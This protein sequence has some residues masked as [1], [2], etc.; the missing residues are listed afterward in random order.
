MAG[1]Y[2]VASQ[3]RT[4]QVV[5]PTQVVDVMEIGAFS[6]PSNVYF[7]RYIPF[8]SWQLLSG[9]QGLGF[10][11][12]PIVDAIEDS[13]ASGAAAAVTFLQDIDVASGLLADFLE[14][15]VSYTPA[16]GLLPMTT[17]VRY[18]IDNLVIEFAGGALSGLSDA[19][20][21]SKAQ[22]QNVAGT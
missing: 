11:L 17:T 6:E 14:F 8:T 18:P 21:A 10:W 19:L 2:Q 12:Q 20:A 5:G 9:P 15:T 13:L 16:G 3:Q 22:L 1:S 7:Q 4:I